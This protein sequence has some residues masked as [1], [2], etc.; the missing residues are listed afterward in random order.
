[1]RVKLS[2]A[3]TRIG[4]RVK[5]QF[6]NPNDAGAMMTVGVLQMNPS[7]YIALRDAL[8]R[9]GNPASVGNSSPTSG[10]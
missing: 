10:D 2:A 5:V 8:K 7:Q 6:P 9:G 4:V 3:K 1:M